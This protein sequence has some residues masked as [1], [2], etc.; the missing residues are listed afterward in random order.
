MNNLPSIFQGLYYIIFGIWSVLHI[1]SF[2][3]LTGPKTDHWLVKTIG[4][5][6]V[7]VGVTLIMNPIFVLGVSF[8]LSFFIIDI[9]Y[10]WNKTISKIYLVDALIQFVLI[11]TYIIGF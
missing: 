1:A 10:V 6:L 8:A 4:L 9:I 11:V 2:E 3:K 7:S 5:L